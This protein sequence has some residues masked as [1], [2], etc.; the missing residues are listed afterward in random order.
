MFNVVDSIR[1]ALH[2][3]QMPPNR[4]VKSYL[5]GIDDQLGVISPG[6]RVVHSD[7][8]VALE[9]NEQAKEEKPLIG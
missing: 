6:N 1:N 5:Y 4:V 2:K 7:L 9:M 8:R 3:E